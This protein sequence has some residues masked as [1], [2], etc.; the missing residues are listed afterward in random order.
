MPEFWPVPRKAKVYIAAPMP[1]PHPKQGCIPLK[2]IVRDVLKLAETAEEARKILNS[3]KIMVDKKVR[4]EPNFPVGLM[5]VFEVPELHIRCRV[6]MEK[7]GLGLEKIKEEET[8]SKLCRIVGKTTI[9]GGT[10]QLNLHDGRN[11]MIKTGSYRV[12]DSV[13][14]E[15][16]GQKIIRHFSM[17]KGEPCMIIAGRNKG[18][19]GSIKDIKERKSML[20]KSTVKIESE[21]GK[22]IETLKE[23]VMVGVY[24]GEEKG[25]KEKA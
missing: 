2:I 24:E 22:E 13:L 14:I 6:N 16:P 1:G 18:V 12:G 19:K 20:E 9:K 11:I 10:A 7:K 15:I 23:Y 8:S 3:G 21:K 25:K 4:K 5:D 17:K